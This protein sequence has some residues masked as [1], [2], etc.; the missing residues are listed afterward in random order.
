MKA[1]SLAHLADHVLL[2]DLAALVSR[3]R[4]TTCEMLAHIAEVDERKL[5]RPA[6]YPSMHAY[7]VGELRMSEDAASKRIHA[8]R[9]ARQFPAIFAALADGRLHLSAVVLLAPRLEPD[10]ADKLL[11]A[12]AHKTSE[13][14]RLLIAN[15]FPQPDLVTMVQ[16]VDA[17][18][19]HALEHVAAHTGE[20]APEHV[21]ALATPEVHAP[22]AK[23]APLSP[24]RFAIQF[25]ADQETYEQLR[26]AQALLG[27]SEPTGDVARIFKR[28]LDALVDKLERRKFAKC[29]WSRPQRGS[30]N[31]RYVP[32]AVRRAVWQ[33][34][35][36]QCTFVSDK[37]RRCAA[38]SALELD[39]IDPVAR[40]GETTAGNLRLRCRAH[41]QY[42]AECTFGKEF[43][44]G[45]RVQARHRAAQAKARAKD[46][47]QAQSQAL[48][49]VEAPQ[50]EV[51][52]KAASHL[53]VIPWLCRLGF[54]AKEAKNAVALC[55][56]IPEGPLEE[57]VRVALRGL[58]PPCV[59][60]PA[61]VATSPS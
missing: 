37:G 59:R 34:D 51:A 5:Y 55:A 48:V 8:A 33:R 43:M 46:Q 3:D 30:T 7:C 57:R 26:H 32:A 15:H 38:D 17:A 42:A 10:N 36:G 58:A 16:A 1:Y 40:G 45:K 19:Q 11:A 22:R 39:H 25:T 18:G 27:H 61:P 56:Q 47:A 21:A 14:I 29:V 31:G 2:R 41:N 44:R 23:L 54:S 49:Q 9:A 35:G 60:R 50:S 24:G 53:D 4:I 6:A 52:V 13:E 28:A 20:H 12:A